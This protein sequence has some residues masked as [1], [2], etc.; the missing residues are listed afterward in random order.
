MKPQIEDYKM[1]YFQFCR[2][3]DDNENKAKHVL[4]LICELHRRKV[5]MDERVANAICAACFHKSSR[6]MIAALRFLHG[7]DEKDND[8]E[9]SDESSEEEEES[10][11]SVSAA[12]SREAVY[13]AFHKGTASSRKKK[14]AKLERARRSLKKQQRLQSHGVDRGSFAPLQHL[15]DPQGFAEKLFARLNTCNE[16]FEV[17]LMLMMVVSRAVGM[18][19]LIL[20]NFYP[21][22]QRYIQPHQRDV[23]Q[24]LATA[25]QACHDM[26]PP[27][28]VEPMLRQLVNQFVHDRAR[29]EVIAVGLNVVREIC[30]RIPLIMTRELLQDLA[31]YKKSHEKAV[32]SAARSIIA[33][34]RQ[35]CPSLLEK[36]DRGRNANILAQPKAFGQI[37]VASDVPGAELLLQQNENDID[38][39]DDDVSYCGS[40]SEANSESSENA[41]DKVDELDN[42]DDASTK[43]ASEV[44]QEQSEDDEDIVESDSGQDW[45]DSEEDEKEEECSKEQTGMTEAMLNCAEPLNSDYSCGKKRKVEEAF[46]VK[47][48]EPS[49]NQ[50]LRQLKKLATNI[51]SRFSDGLNGKAKDGILSNEDFE[52][53]RQLQAKQAAE[54]ALAKQGIGK[55][56]QKRKEPEMKLPTSDTLGNRRV[57][58]TY[59]EAKIHKRREK[60]ERL[61]SARAGREDRLAYGA[62]TAIKKKKTGGLSN[63]Q[64]E[65]RK[66]LPLAAKRAKIAARSREQ[67]RSKSRSNKQFR[68][69]KAWK[70]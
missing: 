17:K 64:K 28:A 59:L 39:L 1:H 2:A 35:L 33:V 16:R 31:M 12:V 70:Q 27:D 48:E 38:I 29:P 25:V 15:H 45:M 22:V 63:R 24:L 47:H 56:N 52:H 37:V 50:S 57:N 61:A 68:G 66:G 58:P 8:E 23:T 18:H 6:I 46:E 14:Q 60:E 49:T 20:L 65:K 40:D 21:Y 5:W 13:K 67:K 34:Y 11:H 44:Q 55:V 26:V 4:A 42:L 53:I 7:Y 41:S 36:R 62:R 19:R 69:K 43:S 9:D 3:Q 30:L 54:A 10:K 32:A 51:S